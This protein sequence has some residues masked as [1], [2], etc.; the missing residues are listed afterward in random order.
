MRSLTHRLKWLLWGRTITKIASCNQ[1]RPWI[2]PF[3]YQEQFL[4]DFA[5]A[6]Q[7]HS[8]YATSILVHI[9]GFHFYSRSI[10]HMS[11]VLVTS[12]SAIIKI[13]LNSHRPPEHTTNYP[14]SHPPATHR[15]RRNNPSLAKALKFK[16][17]QFTPCKHNPFD[18]LQPPGNGAPIQVLSL[19]R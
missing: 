18:T 13:R 12:F 1:V 16:P 5:S 7:Y 15:N 9:R 3:D 2:N 17:T 4:L 8:S 11:C 10:S 6:S 14:S 19:T